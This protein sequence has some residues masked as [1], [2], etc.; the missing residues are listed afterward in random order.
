MGDYYWPPDPPPPTPEERRAALEAYKVRKERAG[1]FARKLKKRGVVDNV[2]LIR[3]TSCALGI[4]EGEVSQGIA[5]AGERIDIGWAFEKVYPGCPLHDS[6][7]GMVSFDPRHD[8][9]ALLALMEY[10][11][12]TNNNVVRDFV[13]QIGREIEESDG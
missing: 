13:R 1:K 11:R 10:S 3:I 8:P 4:N 12:A 9:Y 5:E 7:T 6:R 2:G